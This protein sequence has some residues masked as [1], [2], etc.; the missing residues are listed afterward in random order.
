MPMPTSIAHNREGSEPN[1]FGL[2]ERG[3]AG[4]AEGMDVMETPPGRT[5]EEG[6]HSYM[7]KRG[8]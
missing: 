2:L 7:E 8:G 3:S 6:S 5:R 4:V 1:A